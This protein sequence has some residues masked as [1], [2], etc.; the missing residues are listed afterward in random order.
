VIALPAVAALSRPPDS[1]GLAPPPGMWQSAV[2]AV[3]QQP[4]LI[5]QQPAPAVEPPPAPE[6]R[7]SV[8]H[9]NSNG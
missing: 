7:V 5:A 2:A 1:P 6:R 8:N 4:P 9:V 3:P